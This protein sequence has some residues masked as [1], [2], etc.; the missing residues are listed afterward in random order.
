LITHPVPYHATLTG[1]LA[2]GYAL[3]RAWPSSLKGVPAWPK[4]RPGQEDVLRPFVT[5]HP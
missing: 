3:N 1:Q 4:N 5:L 2:D